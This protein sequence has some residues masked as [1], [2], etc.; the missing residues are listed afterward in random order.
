MPYGTYGAAID[1]GTGQFSNGIAANPCTSSTYDAAGNII[2]SG[3]ICVVSGHAHSVSQDIR[4]GVGVTFGG[5]RRLVWSL[6]PLSWRI[7]ANPR[8]EPFALLA[9]QIRSATVNDTNRTL[10]VAKRS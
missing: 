3:T 7:A 6:P 2:S 5:C 10:D 1:F 8:C 9:R 4:I